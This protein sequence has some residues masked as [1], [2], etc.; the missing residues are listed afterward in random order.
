M[1]EA[2]GPCE[3]DAPQ[4]DPQE[5]D[6]S[7]LSSGRCALSWTDAAVVA[8]CLAKDAEPLCYDPDIEEAYRS[9]AG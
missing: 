4:H 7:D 2:W 1:G 3:P 6:R 8:H 5:G 9:W